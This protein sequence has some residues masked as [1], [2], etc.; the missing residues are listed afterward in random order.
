MASARSTLAAATDLE[1]RLRTSANG[2][3]PT[4]PIGVATIGYVER[5]RTSA[6]RGRSATSRSREQEAQIQVRDGMTE[7]VLT[8][9][10]ALNLREA[11]AKITER[12]VG[13]QS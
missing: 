6:L 5:N 2:T 3:H 9:G 13:P 4:T 8:I 12:N 1:T 10:P 7:I 11:A